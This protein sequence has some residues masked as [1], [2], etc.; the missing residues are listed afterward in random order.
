MVLLHG[1]FGAASGTRNDA[2]WL[3][4]VIGI[5]FLFFVY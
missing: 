4:N 1:S 2:L 3:I 5:D